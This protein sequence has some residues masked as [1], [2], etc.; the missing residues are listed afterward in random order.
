MNKKNAIIVLGIIILSLFIYQSGYLNQ[1]FAL[2]GTSTLNV[3]NVSLESSNPFFSGNAILATFTANSKI[4][5]SYYGTLSAS[6]INNSISEE[7][8]ENGFKANIENLSSWCEYNLTQQPLNLYDYEVIY[9][10]L[11]CVWCSDADADK[12]LPGC[13]MFGTIVDYGRISNNDYTGYCVY[14]NLI[15]SLKGNIQTIGDNKFTAQTTFQ[16]DG[17]GKQ[18]KTISSTEQSVWFPTEDNPNAYLLWQGNLTSGS[19]CEAPQDQ[20]ITTV[21]KNGQYI[22]TEQSL[23]SEYQIRQTQ[24]ENLPYR[25][26]TNYIEQRV[27]NSD[28]YRNAIYSGSQWNPTNSNEIAFIETGKIKYN[29]NELV[30]FPVFSMYVKADS[31]GIFTANPEARINFIQGT[32]IG[33]GSQ[34]SIEVNISNIGQEGGSFT[35]GLDCIDSW[36]NDSQTRSSYFNAQQTYSVFVPITGS[37]S[38]TQSTQC[39]ASV[40]SLGETIYSSYANVTCQPNQTCIPNQK[41]CIENK[42]QQCN[43]DGTTWLVLNDCQSQGKTCGSVSGELTCIA[44]SG[45]P[46]PV[47]CN[48]LEQ[49]KTVETKEFA[50][51]GGDAGTGFF[52]F[53]GE[54]TIVNSG[55]MTADWVYLGVFFVIIITA[56]FIFFGGKKK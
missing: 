30:S 42:V 52:G 50:L 6:Q 14:K 17:E 39:R 49:W 18:Y 56:L 3:S 8:V 20:D 26:S 1:Y 4:N 7:T 35:V 45:E 36:V 46:D 23:I 25:P 19:W 5:Q 16:I 38:T 43:S 37:C 40:T 28:A 12:I 11:E 44:E 10:D 48:F 41:S 13:A 24:L 53:F 47:E 27:I 2:S 33:D 31:L 51:W 34:G 32:T 9:K 21:Y 54:K 15:S 55:C 22:I 29:L